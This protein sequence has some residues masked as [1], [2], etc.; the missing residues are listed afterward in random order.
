MT[1]RSRA[2]RTVADAITAFRL[3]RP[4][5]A[6]TD[7]EATPAECRVMCLAELEQVKT[8]DS[9]EHVEMHLRAALIWARGANWPARGIENMQG[10]VPP[11]C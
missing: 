5:L 6:A 2:D 4:H 8:A 1:E 10:S 7:T 9:I 3:D 11:W